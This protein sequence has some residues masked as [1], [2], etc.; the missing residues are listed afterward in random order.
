MPFHDSS[1]IIYVVE[2]NNNEEKVGVPRTSLRLIYPGGGWISLKMVFHP[3][4]FFESGTTCLFQFVP[5]LIPVW[6]HRHR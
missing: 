2:E 5:L 4:H 3:A 6:G 1:S